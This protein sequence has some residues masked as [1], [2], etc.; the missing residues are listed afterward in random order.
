MSPGV[1]DR[2]GRGA[3]QRGQFAQQPRFAAVD[4]LLDIRSVAAGFDQRDDTQR[5]DRR[6]K[7][8]MGARHGRVDFVRPVAADPAPRA[9]G[10]L[11]VEQKPD[12]S[13]DRRLD[14]FGSR[15][16]ERVR[17]GRFLIARLN[18]QSDQNGQQ[19]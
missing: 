8:M 14:L 17:A 9:V 2:I 5:G 13:A 16:F 4:R 12:A 6:P 15:R 1:V 11:A 19:R 18:R 3:A 7:G 10:V